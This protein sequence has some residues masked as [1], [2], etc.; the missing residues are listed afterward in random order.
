MPNEIS[1]WRIEGI[2]SLLVRHSEIGKG[3]PLCCLGVLEKGRAIF[4]CRYSVCPM[5]VCQVRFRSITGSRLGEW[6]NYWHLLYFVGCT[7]LLWMENTKW[8]QRHYIYRGIWGCQR[9]EHSS[10]STRSRCSNTRRCC[11]R[12]IC[13]SIRDTRVWMGF[14]VRKCSIYQCLRSQ[15]RP[16]LP[17]HRVGDMALGRIPTQ[18]PCFPPLLPRDTTSFI[19]TEFLPGNLSCRCTIL[20]ASPFITLSLHIYL[21]NCQ[22]QRPVH[23][24][25]QSGVSQNSRSHHQSSRVSHK[26][27]ARARLP[28]T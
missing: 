11:C 8:S 28:D 1:Q 23:T 20:W 9:A 17:R 6:A 26:W 4:W 21:L 15:V 2:L 27:I 16:C 25:G 12:R 19:Y 7:A 3:W 5:F 13:C 18:G 24:S 22:N 14:P 10:P